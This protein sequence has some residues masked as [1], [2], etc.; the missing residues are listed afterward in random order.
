MRS[1]RH[2][3]LGADRVEVI[4]HG[5]RGC[6]STSWLKHSACASSGSSK[7]PDTTT[8]QATIP[9][10]SLGETNTLLR[11]AG[12]EVIT[13]V[14]AELGRGRGGGHCQLG[15]LRQRLPRALADRHGEGLVDPSLSF[16]RRRFGTS[17]GGRPAA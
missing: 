15:Q 16:R 13:I 6:S 4:D 8:R 1:Q 7:R 10:V 11:K 17:H 2:G 9:S 12:V 3:P 14:G 5:A